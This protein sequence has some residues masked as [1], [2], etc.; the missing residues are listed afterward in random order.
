MKIVLNIDLAG[1]INK[2]FS[3]KVHAQTLSFTFSIKKKILK[4]TSEIVIF[5]MCF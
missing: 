3:K 2:Y 4:M 1:F 5:S